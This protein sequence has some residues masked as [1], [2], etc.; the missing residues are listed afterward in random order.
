MNLDPRPSVYHP[1]P[2]LKAN[3]LSLQFPRRLL[4]QRP[5][6]LSIPPLHHNHPCLAQSR[7]K[8]SQ[9]TTEPSE[10]VALSPQDVADL[11][12]NSDCWV[13][14]DNKVYDVTDFIPA[15]PGGARMLLN[16][17]GRDATAASRP[18]HAP[19]RIA[20]ALPAHKHLGELDYNSIKALKKSGRAPR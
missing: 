12:T 20:A 1:S 19:P 7:W 6:P 15:H 2:F 17:A 4:Y 11:Y 13:I 18:F 3:Q 10:F 8:R 5:S 9:N 16:F 14:V